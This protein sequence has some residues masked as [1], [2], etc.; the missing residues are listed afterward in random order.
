MLNNAMEQRSNPR[1]SHEAISILD[2]LLRTLMIAGVILIAGLMIARPTSLAMT[3]ALVSLVV[4]FLLFVLASQFLIS[5][6]MFDPG[7]S[8]AQKAK[9]LRLGIPFLLGWVAYSVGGILLCV[10]FLLR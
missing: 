8:P 9:S 5:M 3:M 7:M 1:E 6:E 10:N 2:N 4:G